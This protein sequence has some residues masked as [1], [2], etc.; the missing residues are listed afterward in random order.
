VILFAGQGTSL[1]ATAQEWA[2]DVLFKL[3]PFEREDDTA[4]EMLIAMGTG[5]SRITGTV[6]S[7]VLAVMRSPQRPEEMWIFSC[8]AKDG[9]TSQCEKIVRGF[10]LLQ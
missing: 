3:D 9:G 10:K 1:E 5:P 4:R 6:Q 2:E 7:S 8:Q